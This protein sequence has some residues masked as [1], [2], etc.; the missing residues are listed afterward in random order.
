MQN[1]N[2]LQMALTFMHISAIL[3]LDKCSNAILIFV[4]LF[5]RVS[6]IGCRCQRIT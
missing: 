5:I 4:F 6:G 2:I 1:N 3:R